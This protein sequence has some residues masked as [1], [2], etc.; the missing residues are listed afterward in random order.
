MFKISKKFLFYSLI[1]ISSISL[2]NMTV[3]YWFPIQIPLS[4]YSATSLMLTSYFL[5]TYYLIPVGYSICILILFAASS[6][7]KEQVVLPIALL[8]YFLSDLF[9]LAYSFFDAWLNDEHF[10]VAQ[11]IQIVIS[12]TVIIFMCIYFIFLRGSKKTLERSTGDGLL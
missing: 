2:I 4:S 6:F 9:F 10:I 3:L 12:I 11:A 1:I 5:K 8:V 7:L